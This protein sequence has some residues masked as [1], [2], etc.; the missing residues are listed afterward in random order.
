MSIL[1]SRP[2]ATNCSMATSHLPCKVAALSCVFVLT[3]GK[4]AAWSPLYYGDLPYLLTA[5]AAGAQFQFFAIERESVALPL[6]VGPQLNLNLARDRAELV[7]AMINLH[8]LLRAVQE[9]L[10]N[11]VLPV[12]LPQ[13]AKHQLGYTRT[14]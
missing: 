4:M 13:R 11:Y 12:D 1:P 9:L 3:A 14:L 5:A 6:P 7:I 8:R 2:L 10:P